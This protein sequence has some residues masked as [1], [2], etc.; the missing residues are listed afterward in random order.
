MKQIQTIKSLLL[1]ALAAVSLNACNDEDENGDIFGDGCPQ[2]GNV[3]KL[4]GY[5]YEYN[6]NGL[7]TRMSQ[8][9]SQTGTLKE[10]VRISYP[11]KNRAVMEYIESFTG[12]VSTYVFAFGTDNFAHR[13]IETD[14]EGET[15]TMTLTYDN[16]GHLTSYTDGTGMDADEL[17]LEWTNGNLTKISQNEHHAYSVLTYTNDTR[18]DH[19][20]LSP[21]LINLQYLGPFMQ[22][23]EWWFDSGEWYA[24]YAGFLGKPVKNLPS[25]ITSYD[26]VNSE[27][28]KTTLYWPED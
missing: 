8:P 1:C 3:V 16:E 12:Q 14:S 11:Q 13:I 25:T 27:P 19:F 7:I 21:F 17:K 22:S 26:D 18:F 15:S 9:D 2:A 20:G 10:V 5:V 23:L 28:A 6:E 4:P 24:F